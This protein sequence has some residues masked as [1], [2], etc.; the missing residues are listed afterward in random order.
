MN[1][2]HNYAFVRTYTTG[3]NIDKDRLV[4]L[5]AVKTNEK[6]E[7]IES[8]KA[9]IKPFGNYIYEDRLNDINHFTAED[10]KNGISLDIAYTEFYDFCKDTTIVGYNF[11]KLGLPIL[12]LEFKRMGLCN[13]PSIWKYRQLDLCTVARTL[14]IENMGII[15]I[16]NYFNVE[17][18]KDFLYSLPK[19]FE[20]LTSSITSEERLATL[21]SPDG[22]IKIQNHN[23][24]ICKGKYSGITIEEF[25]HNQ[26]STKYLEFLRS[27]SNPHTLKCF[28]QWNKLKN[29]L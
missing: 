5:E 17:F 13:M 18:D 1:Y 28:Y 20:R 2:S 11:L 8:Y 25:I 16:F 6:Y 24:Y 26:L 7:F 10:V 9:I 23:A 12:N 29:I 27:V 4:G 14:P 19:V 22:W 3:M 21:I 15:S